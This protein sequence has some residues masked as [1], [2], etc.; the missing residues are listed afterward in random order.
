MAPHANPSPL[1]LGLGPVNVAA[2]N[3]LGPRRRRAVMWG[4]GATRSV[5]NADRLPEGRRI[6]EH[7]EHEV[8]HIG[9]GDR[10][11]VRHIGAH[12]GP[13]FWRS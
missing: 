8:G 9:A 2:A 6:V 12:D 5:C 13:V 1:A 4:W 7:G 10:V 11:A 3:R